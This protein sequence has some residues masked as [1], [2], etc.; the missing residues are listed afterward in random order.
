M[1]RQNVKRYGITVEDLD[2]LMEEQDGKC[3]ICAV[4]FDEV[5]PHID[6]D[7]SCCPGQYSCGEC[8]RGLLCRDCNQGLGF[9]RDSSERLEAAMTYLAPKMVETN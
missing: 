3:A 2:R 1:V 9:F 4:S 5:R 8:I 6:H 7:H